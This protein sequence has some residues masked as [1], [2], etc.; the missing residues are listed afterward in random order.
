M[1]IQRSYKCTEGGNTVSLELFYDQA[2]KKKIRFIHDQ[3]KNPIPLSQIWIND[4]CALHIRKFHSSILPEGV[5][6]KKENHHY[7]DFKGDWSWLSGGDL[8]PKNILYRWKNQEDV[9][10]QLPSFLKV[11]GLKKSLEECIGKLGDWNQ[12]L[13][14]FE[15]TPIREGLSIGEL[16][17]VN[18]GSKYAIDVLVPSD[19][20][21]GLSTQQKATGGSISA[22][23][24]FESY[25]EQMREKIEIVCQI[26]IHITTKQGKSD[27]GTGFLIGP[28][29]IMTNEHVIHDYL[30]NAKLNF[31]KAKFFYHY[32]NHHGEIVVNI[33]PEVVCLSTNPGKN[34]LVGPNSFDYAILRLETEGLT[35]AQLLILYNLG[36]TGKNFY[37]NALNTFN[38]KQSSIDTWRKNPSCDP[39]FPTRLLKTAAHRRKRANIIQHPLK[40][41]VSQLKQIAFRHNRAHAVGA[42][43]HY[44][45][46]T[47]SGSSGAPV[48]SDSG[49][50]IGVHYAPCNEF[51]KKLFK[52]VYKLCEKFAYQFSPKTD[53]TA[54][55]F[56]KGNEEL[57]VFR[58]E[59]SQGQWSSSPAGERF[60]LIDLIA[61]N[62]PIQTTLAVSSFVH[63]FLREQG[64][65]ILQDHTFC[66]S[67]IAVEEILKDLEKNQKDKMDKAVQ[68]TQQEWNQW[69]T[70]LALCWARKQIHWTRNQGYYLAGLVAASLAASVAALAIFRTK[71]C[72]I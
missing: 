33:A 22:I 68:K 12:Y 71:R 42:T 47:A 56:S 50:W 6:T 67:A 66:N 20:K 15:G 28:S 40:G 35:S 25:I 64:E 7:L 10:K 43:L 54:F 62:Q 45:S 23:P 49:N 58:G 19:L 16:A 63:T 46:R 70:L 60:T 44:P 8:P 34:R 69:S 17:G 59:E 48:I 51:N 18:I 27:Y 39:E 5:Y 41:G 36:Q 53:L 1:T 65:H 24:V 72:E 38:A 31:A 37:E 61:R 9:A 2:A 21:K 30:V 14:Y 13:L 11:S 52:H 26:E 32:E 29:L 55:C 4:I 3:D 57:Y